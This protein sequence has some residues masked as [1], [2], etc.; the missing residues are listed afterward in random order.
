MLALLPLLN[1]STTSRPL[2]RSIA[3]GDGVFAGIDLALWA[4]AGLHAVLALRA[5]RHRPR[6]VVER[7]VDAPRMSM[8]SERPGSGLA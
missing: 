2:W 5:A 8:A 4:F 6:T 1:A 3:E 7:R